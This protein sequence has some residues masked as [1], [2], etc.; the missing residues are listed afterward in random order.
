MKVWSVRRVWRDPQVQALP[1]LDRV[2]FRRWCRRGAGGL[3]WLEGPRYEVA[4]RRVLGIVGV[5]VALDPDVAGLPRR[6]RPAARLGA[7]GWEPAA[8]RGVHSVNRAMFG[9]S[10]PSDGAGLV[11]S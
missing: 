8:A 5:D 6:R 4:R 3:W 11:G 10:G 1:L 2:V 9:S 7:V